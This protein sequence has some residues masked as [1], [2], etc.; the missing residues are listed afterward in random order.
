MICMQPVYTYT[1]DSV[2]LCDMTACTTV[3]NLIGG[4]CQ[5]Q[6]STGVDR[7]LNCLLEQTDCIFAG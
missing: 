6:I 4:C 1:H 7:H 3:P 2:P 5:L